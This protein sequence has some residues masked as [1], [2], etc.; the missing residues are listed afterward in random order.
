M[1][2]KKTRN[3]KLLRIHTTGRNN[4]TDGNPQDPSIKKTNLLELSISNKLV[5]L[6]MENNSCEG[7]RLE[8]HSAKR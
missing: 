2:R 3:R 7:S 1:K 5:Q 8:I 6:S 4:K